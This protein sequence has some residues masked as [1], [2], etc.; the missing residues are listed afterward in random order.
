MHRP[1]LLYIEDDIPNGLIFSQVLS[2]YFNVEVINSVSE[3]VTHIEQNAYPFVLLD[4]NLGDDKI[5][6]LEILKL[7]RKNPI[8]AHSK[9]IAIT[10]Y[11]MPWDRDN[12]LKQGF[13]DYYS[14]PVDLKALISN[15]RQTNQ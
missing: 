4:I 5:N 8:H 10:S 1:K 11:S 9:V 3:A 14:K 2:P 13:D 15:L 6:G 12:F 7:I